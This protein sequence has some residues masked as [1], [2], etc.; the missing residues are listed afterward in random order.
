MTVGQLLEVLEEIRGKELTDEYIKQMQDSEIFTA[1]NS[2]GLKTS[3]G[4][5]DVVDV[6]PQTKLAEQNFASVITVN[7]SGAEVGYQYHKGTP[8]VEND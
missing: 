1:V 2:Y 8:L 4:V 5:L 7:L 6:R 3:Q